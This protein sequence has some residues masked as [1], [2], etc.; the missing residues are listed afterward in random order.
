MVLSQVHIKLVDGLI[1]GPVQAMSCMQACASLSSNP[2]FRGGK[3]FVQTPF[4][5]SLKRSQG[6]GVQQK[7]EICSEFI[8]IK[9]SLPSCKGEDRKS[10][11]ILLGHKYFI[12]GTWIII[13]CWQLVDTIPKWSFHL[14]FYCKY[15]TT[16]NG[17]RKKGCESCESGR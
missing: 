8:Y 7:W 6:L 16:G 14:L 3:H 12:F 5:V 11:Q 9:G 2:R 17:T 10:H 15:K 13:L 1:I 4:G